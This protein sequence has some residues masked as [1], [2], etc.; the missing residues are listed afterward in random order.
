MA[1]F[2]SSKIYGDL[3]ITGDIKS[4]ELTNIQE[5]LNNKAD[6]NHNH[7]TTYLNLT[8][9]TEF[10]PTDNYHP[11]TK[12]YVDDMIISVRVDLGNIGTI[13][14]SINGEVI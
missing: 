6:L 12:K 8:N 4:K 9:T 2:G 7:N 1:E 14:D 3:T 5:N 10:S 13:L 11:A